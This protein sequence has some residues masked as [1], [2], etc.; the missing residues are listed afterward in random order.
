MQHA[1]AAQTTI[2]ADPHASQ[3]QAVSSQHLPNQ[4]HSPKTEAAN[5]LREQEFANSQSCNG[6]QAVLPHKPQI[7]ALQVQNGKKHHVASQSAWV[8]EGRPPDEAVNTQHVVEATTAALTVT[9]RN[10]VSNPWHA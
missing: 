3:A 2:T 9:D 7:S 1:G 10:G 4:M 6:M 5:E 8:Q